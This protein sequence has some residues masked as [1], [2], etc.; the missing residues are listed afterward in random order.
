MELYDQE[1][2][3]SFS[4]VDFEKYNKTVNKISDTEILN[5]YVNTYTWLIMF[6]ISDTLLDHEGFEMKDIP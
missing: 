1:L 4:H 5:E 2:Q 3:C 6:E